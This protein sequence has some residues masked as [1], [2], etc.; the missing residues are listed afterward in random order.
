MATPV[1]GENVAARRR[2]GMFGSEYGVMGVASA[3]AGAL[4]GC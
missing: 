1:K 3:L 4:L 2:S